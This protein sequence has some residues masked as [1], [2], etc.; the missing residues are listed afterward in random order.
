IR[1]Q[2]TAYKEAGDLSRC[3]VYRTCLGY[4]QP[5]A[6]TQI[7]PFMSGKNA[8]SLNRKQ[9]LY[10]KPAGK[11]GRGVFCRAKIR[12][13]EVLETTPALIL[14]TRATN[15]TGPTIINDYTFMIG[16]ITKSAQKRAGLRKVSS[17]SAIVMGIMAY[18]NHDEEPNA[19]IVWEEKGTTL[20]YIL[21]AT[22]EIP[23]NTE[24]CTSYGEG[25]FEDRE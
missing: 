14:D 24:I 1:F 25:W 11:K 7:E 2:H 23:R 17:A 21:R 18:C 3:L 19:E 16:D 6:V 5:P 13:G 9:G 20:Y 12:K 22:R 15:L 8:P 10:L 4:F